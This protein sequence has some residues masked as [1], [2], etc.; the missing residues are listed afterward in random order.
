[1]VPDHERYYQAT[2]RKNNWSKGDLAFILNFIK[3][4]LSRG[5]AEPIL[6]IGCGEAKLLE[7]L[8]SGVKYI[9][10]DP[11]EI[12]I[13]QNHT[14][15]PQQDFI[16][17]YAEQLPVQDSSC[18]LIFLAQTIQSFSDPRKALMEMFRVLIP[19]GHIIVMAP[20]L[21]N[22]WSDVPATRH[23]SRFGQAAFILLRIW[24]LVSRMFGRLPFRI[25]PKNI[26]EATGK[27]ERGDDDLRYVTSAYEVVTYAR[28][29]GFTLAYHKPILIKPGIKGI[30]TKML[31]KIPILAYYQGGM[32]LIFT[33]NDR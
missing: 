3:E 7:H 16:V 15:F 30:I 1:M 12:V 31:V 20:N 21:E 29:T 33:K 28:K 14:K 13:Q 23:Y 11:S 17:G 8:P 2:R 22:P 24:D 6:E 10:L 25:L 18:R 5:E 32:V 26:V 9:G 4:L 19:G 27:F